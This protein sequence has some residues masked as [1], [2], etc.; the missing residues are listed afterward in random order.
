MFENLSN[1]IVK[2]R[3]VH[4]DVYLWNGSRKIFQNDYFLLRLPHHQFLL[5]FLIG[6]ASKR[7]SWKGKFISS[8][9]MHLFQIMILIFKFD[10]FLRSLLSYFNWHFF[11]NIAGWLVFIRSFISYYFPLLTPVLTLGTDW[12]NLR[13][14]PLFNIFLNRNN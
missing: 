2:L 12:K 1:S 10:F 3:N 11:I 5:T 8:F 4:L 14:F 13:I 6:W 9:Q 7:K